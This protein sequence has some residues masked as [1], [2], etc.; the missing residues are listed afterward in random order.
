[1]GAPILAGLGLFVMALLTWA[2]RLLLP[3]P[4][5]GIHPL[6]GPQGTAWGLNFVLQRVVSLPLWR[7]VFQSSGI[8]R[9]LLLRALG[10]EVPFRL[11]TAMDAEILDAHL[12]TIGEDAM[13]SGGTS[14]SAH[15]TAGDQLHL[16]RVTIG[17]S[18]EL[19][20]GASVALGCELGEGTRVGV[21]TMILPHVKAGRGCSIGSFVR[22]GEGTQIGEG[23]TIGDEVIVGRGCVIEAGATV[24]PG[25]RLAPG[26]RVRAS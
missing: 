14:V 11:R 15:L 10:A 5:P 9:W 17:R 2:L 6:Q 12:L 13:L 23:A 19:W 20:A 4:Q 25:T 3:R 16:A 1:M 18:V 21:R 26:S 8:L 24:A 7:P 22:V